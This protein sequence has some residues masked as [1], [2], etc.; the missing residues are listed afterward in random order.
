VASKHFDVVV[1][2]GGPGGYVGAIRAAQLGYKT[3]IIERARLGGVCLNWGCIPSK[4][5]IS[6]AELMEKLAEKEEWGIE[7]GEIKFNWDKVI[8]RSRDV[9]SKLNKGVEFLMKKNKIEFFNKHAKI[10]KAG[11]GSGKDGVEIE[12]HDCTLQEELTPSPVEVKKKIET[13]TADKV[14][15]ATGA[16]ARDLPFAKFDGDKVWGSREAMY[17]KERPEKLIIVG[18]GAIGCEFGYVYK[19]F[20][21][22]VTLIEMLERIVPV[23]DEQ[24]GKE[25]GKIYKKQGFDIRT[26]TG[27]V[28][29]D[30]SGKGVK[31]TVAPM[32]DGKPDESKKETIEGDKVLLAIGVQGRFDGLF[33]ES[34]GLETVKGHIKT[35]Y[36][37]LSDDTPSE[38]RP[39]TYAT[40]LPGIY[41]I[42]DVIGPPWLAHVAG[43]EAI[44]C[45]ERFAFKEGKL[46]HEPI[47]MDYTVIPGCTYC[48]PQVGSVGYT[49]QALKKQGL[50]KG[51]DYEVG[52]FQNQALG[53]AIATRN[54]Y[55]FVKIIRG[56]PR[57]EILGTHILG[58]Q[59]TELIAEMTLAR[60]MEATSEEIIATVHAH[61]TMHEAV[62]EAALASE[63]RVINS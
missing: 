15:I 54:T 9:A 50:K 49:E 31:V 40:N 2:G 42:G 3:A 53:K 5:M 48:H 6:N 19:Q 4:A 17:N 25:L 8:G 21:T 36:V 38:P 14:I 1:I 13:I 58:D 63:G 55:G 20:G 56:L 44:L 26:S 52:V 57:G 24:V 59:A 27:V 41:A 18:A 32:K 28:D 51:E 43:E 60:R 46:D 34:L 47:P 33:D 12:I 16:V 39:L 10:V 30:T 23:E 62:H 37:P 35:D 11:G 7:T 45:V 61:P 29:V 22:Q